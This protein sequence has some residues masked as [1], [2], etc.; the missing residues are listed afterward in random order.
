MQYGKRF[1]QNYNALYN[2]INKV[3]QVAENEFKIIAENCKN[4]VHEQKKIV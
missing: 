2:E 1:V 3:K 4:E